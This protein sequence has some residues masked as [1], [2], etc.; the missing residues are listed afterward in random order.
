MANRL[1]EIGFGGMATV[2]DERQCKDGTLAQSL[3]VVEGNGGLKAIPQPLPVLRLPPLKELL[4]V[5]AVGGVKWY[6]FRDKFDTAQ[7]WV[8]YWAS[9]KEAGTGLEGQAWDKLFNDGRHSSKNGLTGG[10]LSGSVLGITCVGNVVALSTSGEGLRFLRH[11]GGTYRLLSQA[12]PFIPL[13]FSLRNMS[14]KELD[15][16]GVKYRS[17]QYKARINGINGCTMTFGWGNHIEGADG[18]KEDRYTYWDAVY[19]CINARGGW[20]TEHGYFWEPVMV[21]YALRLY[22]GSYVCH[23]SPVLINPGRT[24]WAY[25]DPEGLTYNGTCCCRDDDDK[26]K[27]HFIPCGDAGQL[28]YQALPLPD[29]GDDLEQWEDIVESVDIFVSKPLHLINTDPT[30][31][32]LDGIEPP[33][34]DRLHGDLTNLTSQIKMAR[35]IEGFG[36]GS[37]DMG[38]NS[39]IPKIGYHDWRVLDKKKIRKKKLTHPDQKEA[40]HDIISS[41][42]PPIPLNE[43]FREDVVSCN[44]FYLVS[45]IKFSDI[46]QKLKGASSS[47]ELVELRIKDLSTLTTFETLPDD[48]HS[49]EELRPRV[50]SAYNMR[51]TIGDFDCHPAPLAP[52]KTFWHVPLQMEGLTG[53]PHNNVTIEVASS[54]N[55]DVRAVEGFVLPV[56]ATAYDTQIVGGELNK[57]VKGVIRGFDREYR[58]DFMPLWLYV[59]DPD[60]TW[61]R[62]WWPLAGTEGVE[63]WLPLMKHPTMNG[64]YWIADNFS[65]RFRIPPYAA[66][67][68]S[69]VEN[70]YPTLWPDKDGIVRRK[71]LEDYFTS[72]PSAAVRR[73]FPLGGVPR[74]Q[75]AVIPNPGSPDLDNDGTGGSTGGAGGT[76][77]KGTEPDKPDNPDTP[78][79]DKP[80]P[81]EPGG[82]SGDGVGDSVSGGSGSGND[83][84]KDTDDPQ[85]TDPADPTLNDTGK[86][87]WREQSRLALSEASNPF[88]LP[89]KGRVTVGGGRVVAVEAAVQALSQDTFGR[90][91]LYAFTTD[92]IWAVAV[93]DVGTPSVRQ[94]ISREV[95]CNVR[96]VRGIDNAVVF[97]TERGL[98]AVGSDGCTCLSQALAMPAVALQTLDL[99]PG[100]LPQTPRR[101]LGPFV[102]QEVDDGA[103]D[104]LLR[105]PLPPARLGALEGVSADFLATLRSCEVAYDYEAGRVLVYAPSADTAWVL[106]VGSRNW[107]MAQSRLVRTVNS[108][109]ECWCVE[110]DGVLCRVRQLGSARPDVAAVDVG[111][112]TRAIKLGAPDMLQRL[113]SAR[114]RGVF[115]SGK[116][117]CVIVEGT[118][119]YLS[120]TPVASAE[121]GIMPSVYGAPWKAYRLRL[122]GSMSLADSADGISML[123]QPSLTN[124][125]R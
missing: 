16:L 116:G 46:R 20:L 4:W 88:V 94:P 124:R 44:E 91:P 67:C 69:V 118:R 75:A 23:S 33:V 43:S 38:D 64:T 9:E 25:V 78:D 93:D 99:K 14:R 125:L 54:R 36:S 65:E 97:A 82:G 27:C 77:G 72:F 39:D 12:P 53:W 110:L 49:R 22:D 11:V 55:G 34:V 47:K 51:L 48:Y 123:W 103:L 60:A 92:G 50:V 109:P 26:W 81:V 119:D 5:H 2:P 71:A 68:P 35:G 19:G 28:E 31:T 73:L 107:G 24:A 7:P 59:N 86:W 104:K 121:N 56:C 30:R 76:T 79:P 122:F 8:L 100:V 106:D 101:A 83:D 63:I 108:Y 17:E 70:G 37:G 66:T 32:I 117:L 13:A 42:Y 1:T 41:F 114:L 80:Q 102:G 95:C 15:D 87:I 3:N 6:I 29:E 84:G 45:N 113:V 111:F 112:A 120:W 85:I 74:R 62:I 96:S 52:G 115:A 89:A 21:R 58:S 98:M 10:R 40:Y 61:M 57:Y 105:S 90:H 18:E